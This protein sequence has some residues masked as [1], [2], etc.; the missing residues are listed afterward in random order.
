MDL[1][2]LLMRDY[3][4][5]I[6]FITSEIRSYSDEFETPS[7]RDKTKKMTI[8]CRL[9]QLILCLLD[10]AQNNGYDIRGLIQYYKRD[11]SNDADYAG[12]YYDTFRKIGNLVAL[13]KGNDVINS[14]VFDNQPMPEYVMP[15]D[16]ETMPLELGK[17]YM[18]IYVEGEPR[19]IN[20]YFT[21]IKVSDEEYYLNSSYGSDFVCVPQYT[22]R[23]TAD[24]FIRFIPA[25]NNPDE[26]EYV[27]AFYKKFF[28]KGNLGKTTEIENR[29]T[30]KRQYEDI[31][32]DDGNI[33][34]T[35]VITTNV[36]RDRIR[37]GIMP[38]YNSIVEALFIENIYHVGGKKKHIRRRKTIKKN[39]KTNK[40]NKKS[41]QRRSSRT[42]KRYSR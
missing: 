36:Y 42:S 9:W 26:D 12:Y 19:S 2:L 30:V 11:F 27:I 17:N 37:C 34:E 10:I 22:T 6:N 3:A 39:K 13:A 20:H 23:I 21:V 33:R 28:L 29:K 15:Y 32:P 14:L 24:E 1:D 18:C 4:E 5:A 16:P 38:Q 31:K 40:T 25:L 41:N 8:S 35:A 7:T